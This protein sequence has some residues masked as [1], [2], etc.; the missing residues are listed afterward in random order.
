MRRINL[1]LVDDEALIRQGLRSLLEKEDFVDKIYEAGDPAEFKAAISAK[2]IDIVLLDI[3]LRNMTGLE[4]LDS[5]KKLNP[6]PKVI[7][8]TGMEGVE[9]IIN[10]LKAGVDGIVYKLDGYDENN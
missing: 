3:R 9:L 10:L 7:A 4:L 8:V 6:P 2:K 1:L 5:L